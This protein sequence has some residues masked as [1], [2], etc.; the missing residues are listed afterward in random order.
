VRSLGNRL[1]DFVDRLRRRDYPP[2]LV[3]TMII[4]GAFVAGVVIFNFIIMPILVKRSDVCIVPALQGMSM[5][6]AEQVCG[7][8]KLRVALA[9]TRNSEEVPEGYILQQSPRQGESLKE[10]RTIKVI[11]STGPK[12]EAVPDLSGK[13]VREAEL[14]L[15]GIGLARG[16]IVRVY[17]DAPGPDNSVL[18]ESPAAGSR[19][20]RGTAVDLLIGL[21]GEPKIFVMP[22][23]VGRDLPFVR[24][25]LERMGFNVVRVVARRG[26]SRFPNTIISQKPEPGS[27]IKEGDTIELVVSTVE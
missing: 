25:K 15:E 19:L 21:R 8:D 20:P 16:R 9:G 27:Q 17:S 6:Q 23:L 3:Y 18:T 12:T 13:T 14:Q 1:I 4:V 7:R 24:D 10:G 11:T 26:G 22:N 2:L 5:K